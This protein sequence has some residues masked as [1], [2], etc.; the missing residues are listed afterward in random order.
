MQKLLLHT[1]CAPCYS[2]SID[3][4][5][6][7]YEIDIFWYNPN[8][9]PKAEH[10]KRLDTLQRYLKLMKFGGLFEFEYDYEVENKKWHDWIKGLEN[11]PE[12]GERC[13]KC[14]EFRL[15]QAAKFAKKTDSLFTTTLTI[16]PY[17]DSEMIK[18][19]GLNLENYLVK[20]FKENNGYQ[21]SIEL[22]KQNNIY[23]Q[24]YCGCKYGIR[25]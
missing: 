4:I 6:D 23:R 7:D 5:K 16:S 18:K 17:K 15:K 25:N 14:I 1:C 12:G 3:Q 22:C 19:I 2:G 9:E 20:D 10:D 21:H 8:I 13:K 11:E 24:K